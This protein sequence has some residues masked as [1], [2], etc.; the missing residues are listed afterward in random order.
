M[1]GWPYFG[2]LPRVPLRFTLLVNRVW[3]L[4]GKVIH[5]FVGPVEMRKSP[6][7]DSCRGQRMGSGGRFPRWAKLWRR[8]AAGWGGLL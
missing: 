4:V 5:R 8:F 7:V 6:A 1:Q 2:W 3:L